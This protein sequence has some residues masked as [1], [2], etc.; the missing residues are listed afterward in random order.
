MITLESV[1]KS[2]QSGDGPPLEILRECEWKIGRGE[3]VAVVGPSGSGKSTLLHLLAGTDQADA[4]KVT[5]C[6]QQPSS[7]NAE[8]AAAFRRET[9]GIVFQAHHLLPQLTALENVLLPTLAAG[10]CKG[11]AAEAA[12]GRAIELLKRVGLGER[13]EHLPS[14]LSGGERQRVAVARAWMLKPAVLLA[15][16]P[17][18]ALDAK[19]ATALTQLL[20]DFQRAEGT[21]LIVVTHAESVAEKMDAIWRLAAG[22]LLLQ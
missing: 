15:D 22:K 17:T 11:T 12:R 21:T 18:G 19:N 16:E 10:A 2:Y 9:V 14:R 6:E 13:L 4:G 5:V 7:L 8:A 1:S 20:R 3:A